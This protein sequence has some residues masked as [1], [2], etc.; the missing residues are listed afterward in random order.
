[1]LDGDGSG[2]GVTSTRA[3]RGS[4]DVAGRAAAVGLADDAGDGDALGLLEAAADGEGEP[5]A[6]LAT[7]TGFAAGVSAGAAEV[8]GS[9]SALGRGAAE[10]SRLGV[11]F[12]TV[13]PLCGASRG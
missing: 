11:D 9:A 2:P 12:A 10:T 13:G 1:V 4:L 5:A 6:G 8:K 7:G 3:C